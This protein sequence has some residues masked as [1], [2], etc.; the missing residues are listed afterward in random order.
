MSEPTIPFRD[1][2]EWERWLEDHH[3]SEAGVW[4]KIAKKAG[5]IPGISYTEALDVAL[6]FGWIDSQRDRVDDLYWRQRFTPRTK[7]SPW[8]QV[9]RGRAERLA[10]DGRI[11]PAGQREIDAAMADG[12]W[13]AAYASQSKITVPDDLQEAL[14]E[15][16]EAA[17]FFATLNSRNRYAI[18]YRVQ[19]AKKPET[20]AKRIEKFVTMM[21]N[22]EL[23]YP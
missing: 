13:E 22:H 4:V 5:G 6:C 21:A 19:S 12:R 10:A 3:E 2:A 23:I 20:R 18:L 11:R 15:I 8:S 1:Q 17:E 14:L 9:N 7:R 16:P